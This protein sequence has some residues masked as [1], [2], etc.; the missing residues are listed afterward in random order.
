MVV[1]SKS[2]IGAACGPTGSDAEPLDHE[3]APVLFDNFSFDEMGDFSL[4]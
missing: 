3:F 2:R 4:G 1:V